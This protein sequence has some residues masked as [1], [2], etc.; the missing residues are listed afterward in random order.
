MIDKYKAVWDKIKIF[1]DGRIIAMDWG[2]TEEYKGGESLAW[3][4][5]VEKYGI[6]Y[7]EIYSHKMDES[8]MKAFVVGGI[9]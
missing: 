5:A 7:E 3:K 6:K 2:S 9:K 1:M 4:Q 8:V